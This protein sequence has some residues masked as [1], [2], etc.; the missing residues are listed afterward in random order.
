MLKARYSNKCMYYR[1]M[2]EGLFLFAQKF[3][4]GLFF[5]P[6]FE[7]KEGTI[8]I[9]LKKYINFNKCFERI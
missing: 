4:N 6:P 2:Y 3:H 7:A 9:Y 5:V 1:Y 8:Y